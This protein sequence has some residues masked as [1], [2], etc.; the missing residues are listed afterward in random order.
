[1]LVLSTTSYAIGA[2][3]PLYNQVLVPQTVAAELHQANTPA[4]VQA[5]MINPPEWCQIRPDPP[6]DPA[7]WFL[8]PGERSAITLALSVNAGRLLI[9]EQAGRAEPNAGTCLLPAR[10][11]CWLRR[12]A[13]DC[14]ILKWR[15]CDFAKRISTCRPIWSIVFAG[16]CPV[17]DGTR[18]YLRQIMAIFGVCYNC[19][20][21]P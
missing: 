5:W 9:D 15:L 14:S 6:H 10:W 21:L 12:I 20:G 7:L 4:A 16:A 18:N 17:G 2:L 11:E 8:D 3:Q 13:P 1:M 19:V